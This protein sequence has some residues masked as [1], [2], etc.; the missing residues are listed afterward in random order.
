MTWWLVIGGCLVVIGC[1]RVVANGVRVRRIR[2]ATSIMGFKVNR[3]TYRWSPISQVRF[4]IEG[5]DKSWEPG[6]FSFPASHVNCKA[7]WVETFADGYLSGH[8]DAV[9][10][11]TG[12]I[13]QWPNRGDQ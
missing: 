2:E 7:A 8:S 5:P 9:S 13:Y 1:L 11:F 3:V 4:D 12:Y 10:G 6:R